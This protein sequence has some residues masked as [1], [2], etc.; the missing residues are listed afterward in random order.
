MSNADAIREFLSRSPQGAC[1]DCISQVTHV[2]PRQQV[3]QICR[4]L[5]QRG[6]ITRRKDRCALCGH[7]KTV[8]T[9]RDA[10]PDSHVSTSSRAAHARPE[11]LTLDRAAADS[12]DNASVNDMAHVIAARLRAL[13]S[14]LAQLLSSPPIRLDER[15]RNA[16][17]EVH[18]VYRIFDPT[19][20]S[21]T[22]RAGRTRKAAGGL[23]QRV[24]GNHLMGNQPGNLRAQ[25]VTHGVCADLEVAKRFIR[26]SL[27][28]QILALEDEEERTWLEHFMLAALRPRYCD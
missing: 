16:L 15:C 11:A 19:K 23:R 1:D 2:D 10:A 8:S 5:E 7:T 13:E 25:L 4:R 9:I 24:Y 28:V 22:V 18:G 27:A 20:P 12:I 14:Q 21:E 26:Q 6:T 3:Y 17:P